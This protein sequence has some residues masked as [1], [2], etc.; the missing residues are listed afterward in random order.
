MSS[1]DSRIVEMKFN[2]AQFEKGIKETTSSLEGLKKSLSLDGAKK[3]LENLQEVGKNFSLNNIASGIDNLASKFTALAGI[4]VVALGNIATQAINAGLSMAKALT[5]QPVIEGY[6][7]YNQKLTSIQTITNATGKSIEEVGK[8]FKEL[9]TYADKTIYN[10]SDMTGALAKF[11][12]AGVSLDS[13]VPAIKGISNMVALAGQ[14]ANAASIAYYNLSQSIAGG[15]LTTTDYKSLNLANVAT[16][17]WKQNVINAALAAGKLKKDANGMYNIPGV[18]KAYNDQQLFNDALS[19]GWAS[20]DVL[21]K[22]LGEYGSETTTIGKKAYKAATDVKSFSMMI[23]TLKANVGTGWTDTFEILIGNLEESKQLFTG[24]T[25]TV[26]GFFDSISTARNELLQGWKDLGGRT[27]LIDGIKNAWDA[28]LSV[29]NPIIQAF[30]DIFPAATAKQLYDLTVQFKNFMGSLVLSAKSSENLKNTFRGLFA[31][32]DIIWMAIKGV[33]S[34]FARLLA[35]LSKTGDGILTLTGGLGNMLVNLRDAIKSG[36]FFG[37]VFEFIGNAIAY[38]IELLN[39]FGK[40]VVGSTE[41]STGFAAVWQGIAKGFEV[42]WEFIKPA[43]DWIVESLKVVGDAVSDFFKQMNPAS[44]AAI[45]A[46][47]GVAAAGAGIFKLVQFIRNSFGVLGFGIVDQLQGVLGTLKD[48]LG[49]LQR[50]VQ[51]KTLMNIAIALGVLAAAVLVLSFIP[52][53]RLATALGA[54]TVMLGQLI[55]AMILF[56]KYIGVKG[57]VKMGIISFALIGLATAMVIFAGAIAILSSMDWNELARGLAGMAGALALMIGAAKILSNNTGKLILVAFALNGLATAMV[58]M[59]AAMK[60]FAS[61][62]WDE[63]GRGLAVMAGMLGIIAAFSKVMGGIAGVVSGAVGLIVI[64]GAMM[65]MAGAMKVFAT[66]SW[67]EIGRGL[68]LLAGSLLILVVA[69]KFMQSSILGAAAMILVATAVTI[70]AAAMKI[71]SSMSWD[72]IGKSLVM[73]A[74]SLAILAGAMALMG[75]PLVMAGSVG[76]IAAAVAMM[77]LAPALKMLGKMSWDEIGRG[78]TMLASALGILAIGG[79]LLLAALPGLMGLGVAALLIGAGALAAGIGV[80]MLSAGLIALGAASSVGTAA[81]VFMAT[82]LIGLIPLI[83]QKIGEGIVAIANVI[84]TSGP[85]LIGAFTTVIVSM[86]TAIQTAAPLIIETFFNLISMLVQKLTENVPK[87]VESGI[88]MINGILK[89]I[90]DNIGRMIDEGTRIVTEF[91]N[92]IGRNLPKIIDAGVK[93]IISFVNGLAQ[94][95]RNN[96]AAMRDAGWNLA[97]ALID[98]MTGG[99]GSAMVS[100]AVAAV[101]GLG[102]AVLRAVKAVLGIRSPSKEFFKVGEW[103]GEGLSNGLTSYTDQVGKDAEKLGTSAMDGLNKSISG[104]SD[105]SLSGLDMTPTIRPVLDLS[106]IKKDSTLIDGM[107]TPSALSVDAGYTKA[108]SISVEQKALKSATSATEQAPAPVA[109]DTNISFVQNNTSPK[110][111]TESEIYRMTKNQLSAAKGIVVL[112]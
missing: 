58:I 111:L 105:M 97:S 96:T 77:M 90:A 32:I 5:I 11:T 87:F 82:Q 83:M 47:G 35:P 51:S 6:S 34:V 17:E 76:I 110:A 7:D 22:V 63:V 88:I 2:N 24:L 4:G 27:A 55:A 71:F 46:G 25:N 38:P 3:G 9:D 99:L 53:D 45:L 70:L 100:K 40:A 39:K 54:I 61:L 57:A 69:M 18:A 1:I 68:A 16:N 14:D 64:A 72:E 73:L 26:G 52:V 36:N 86:V 44:F 66:L 78:L 10:L 13:S 102:S 8:Y 15:F 56:D 20:T 19:E 95:I 23:D 59:A 48:Y 41:T 75:I 62:S 37:K 28:V 89:G 30:R 21:L 91:L 31:V 60:I 81:L 85:A 43:V 42:V 79:V 92:G 103:S 65:I 107:L 93:V 112:T 98:G 101:H 50:E 67:D 84:A 49:S 74:G 104:I 12:N 80:T 109:G 33:A 29:L 94:G 108:A 106:S